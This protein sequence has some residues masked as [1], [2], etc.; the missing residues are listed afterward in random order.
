MVNTKVMCRQHLLGEHL[1]LHMFV[2][3]IKK[4]KSISGYIE[5]NLVEPLMI[6]KRHK[7][8]VKEMEYRGYNHY[9][10]LNILDS[11]FK[12]LGIL[13]FS[14][15]NKELARKDLM[16]RCLECKRGL[17]YIDREEKE[18]DKNNGL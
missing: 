16:K 13:K 4:N 10:N 17:L 12:Y 7:Q 8:L 6:I 1:E 18:N 5:K 11:D 3:T 14:K 9:S 15:I 2:G